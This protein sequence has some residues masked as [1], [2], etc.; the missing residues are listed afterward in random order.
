MAKCYTTVKLINGKIRCILA[1]LE[2]SLAHLIVYEGL[3]DF[4]E[5]V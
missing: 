5:S 1:E 3:A 4:A 2:N